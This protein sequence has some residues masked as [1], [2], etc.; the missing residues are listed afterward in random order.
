M[1]AYIE[2]PYIVGRPLTVQQ[3]ELFV[4]RQKIIQRIKKWID[5]PFR[6]PILLYGQHWVG[7]TSPTPERGNA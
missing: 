5:N 3:L 6:P 4:G 1:A 2:N 7:K